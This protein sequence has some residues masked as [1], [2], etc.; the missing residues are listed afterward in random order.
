VGECSF[1]L[2]RISKSKQACDVAGKP[3]RSLWEPIRGDIVMATTEPS[4]NQAPATSEPRK[5]IQAQK[6]LR[7]LQKGGSIKCR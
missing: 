4:I 5:R 6:K 2:D 7:S 3:K 1:F